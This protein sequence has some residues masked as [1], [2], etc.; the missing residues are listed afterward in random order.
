MYYF[1][2]KLTV[3]MD[4]VKSNQKMKQCWLRNLYCH[5][6][7]KGSVLH[8]WKYSWFFTYWAGHL[9]GDHFFLIP[10]K[11]L[12]GRSFDLQRKRK[13]WVCTR[14]MFVSF[15]VSKSFLSLTLLL[16]HFSFS[17]WGNLFFHSKSIHLG[18]FSLCIFLFEQGWGM[19]CLLKSL[20][21]KKMYFIFC[22]FLK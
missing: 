3:T 4:L 10:F 8:F 17:V 6:C 5:L 20:I 21:C 22:G 15:R 16:M 11:E 12:R 14:V 18:H 9:L 1:Q 19:T 7:L 13:P 2:I